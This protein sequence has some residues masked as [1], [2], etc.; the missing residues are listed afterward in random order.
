MWCCDCYI[1]LLQIPPGVN[2]TMCTVS[3]NGLWTVDCGLW[4][5]DCG[6]W[7]K[8]CGPVPVD[9][10][11][12]LLNYSSR[13][14]TSLCSRPLMT[15]EQSGMD[16]LIKYNDPQVLSCIQKT[17][18]KKRSKWK[19]LASPQTSFGVRLS[20]IH[21]SPRDKKWGKWGRN[22]CVTNEPQRTSAGRLGNVLSWL[23]FMGSSSH[24]YPNPNPQSVIR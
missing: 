9:G 12:F 4:T 14:C 22:E 16:S 23:N 5:V 21:F 24:R 2:T 17:I 8:D 6:L 10:N 1:C 20:R 19:C 3:R 18:L 11:S 7:D 15:V 13:L